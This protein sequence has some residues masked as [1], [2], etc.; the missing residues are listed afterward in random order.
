MPPNDRGSPPAATTAVTI[1]AW[2]PML[3][4]LP[5]ATR[6][7]RNPTASLSWSSPIPA[8]TNASTA[9]AVEPIGENAGME[10]LGRCCAARYA[11]A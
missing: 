3:S 11:I 6:R 4:A 2:N 10:P 1:F 9:S 7:L 5:W 8:A